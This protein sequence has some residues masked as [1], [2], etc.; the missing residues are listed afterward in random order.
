ML[1]TDVPPPDRADERPRWDPRVHTLIR[2]FTLDGAVVGQPLTNLFSQADALT[3]VDGDTPGEKAAVIEFLL[4]LC[5]ASGTY[6][7]SSE[8]WKRGWRSSPTRTGTCFIPYVR[9]ARTPFSESS[10]RSTGQGRPNW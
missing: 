6:P 5:Y 10:W 9:L 1:P 7:T 8:E 3:D 4:A 2:A